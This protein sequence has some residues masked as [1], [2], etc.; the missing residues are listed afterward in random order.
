MSQVVESIRRYALGTFTIFQA[1]ACEKPLTETPFCSGWVIAQ[2]GATLTTAINREPAYL[3]L[4]KSN[5]PV[6]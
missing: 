1:T 6:L 2:S 4:L 5:L 3:R